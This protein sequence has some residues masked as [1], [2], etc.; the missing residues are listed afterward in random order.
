[1]R[2][3]EISGTALAI[4]VPSVREKR[5]TSIFNKVPPKSG[6]RSLMV[7][8]I[9]LPDG[10]RLHCRKLNAMTAPA[11]KTTHQYVLVKFEIV[12]NASVAGGIAAPIS[13][14]M[15]ANFGITK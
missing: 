7:S 5:A 6:I 8:Q 1:M 9:R 15:E 12:N 2:T 10:V 11:S 13:W 3:P 14:K 4:R